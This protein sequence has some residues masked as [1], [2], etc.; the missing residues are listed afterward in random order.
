MSQ[1]GAMR[2]WE[3]VELASDV[4]AATVV[5][6]KG[7]DI[8]SVRYLP[9][10]VELLWRSP[11][12]LRQRG[13]IANLP[14]DIGTYM[15]G[16]P[17]GWQT[18]FPNGGD[19]VV[20][21]GAQWGMHGEVCATPFDF[22]LPGDETVV[23]HAVLV[24]SPF[25]I[26][27]QVRVTGDRLELTET[28]TNQGGEPIE[29][30]WSHHPAFGPPL[31]GGACRLETAARTVLV[32]D[33]RDTASGDLAIGGRGTWPAV[34]A[35]D[36]TEIDLGSVPPPGAGIDRMAYLT[37][38]DRGWVALRNPDVGLAVEL[39][40]D[41]ELFPHAWYWLEA[42]GQ[43][44]FPWYQR[45]YVMAVEP[46]TSIPGQGIQAARAKTGSQITFEPGQTRQAVIGL[47]VGPA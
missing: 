3:T 23:L 20:E 38:F 17:G 37:D 28:I 2:G 15:D 30:M 4:L 22:D 42:N 44:G 1:L 33:I 32:D 29:V 45:A 43:T 31:L 19:P 13:A 39:D 47:R 40:W 24:R 16:Y 41:A 27:K 34:P 14:D 7:G 5:P 46:A 12:G 10:D 21:H 11:W 8:V 35:K 6:G 18:I 26:T 9:A 36:G 25:E